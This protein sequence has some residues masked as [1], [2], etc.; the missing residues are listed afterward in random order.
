M[1]PQ[2]MYRLAQDLGEAKNRQN[3]YDALKFMHEDMVL[4]SP[5]WGLVARGK[6]ENAAVLEAFFNDYPDYHVSFDNYVADGSHFIGWGTV[7]MTMAAHAHDAG[8]QRP[9]GRRIT[10][11]VTIRMGFK[12][13]L[14]AHEVFNCDLMQIALQSGITPNTIAN[15]V[16]PMQKEA[17]HAA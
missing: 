14:I 2:D 15:A 13:G 7:Q 3:V 17:D 4:E 1:E 11:P 5:A 6:T 12:D 8:G 16:F 10:L 9:N